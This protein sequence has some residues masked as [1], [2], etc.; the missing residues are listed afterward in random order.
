MDYQT[1]MFPVFA[2]NNL[3]TLTSLYK[4]F[5]IFLFRLVIGSNRLQLKSYKPSVDHFIHTRRFL[6]VHILLYSIIQPIR[7]SIYFSLVPRKRQVNN[8]SFFAQT[9][10]VHVKN[11]DFCAQTIIYLFVVLKKF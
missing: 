5:A 1:G 4:P 3:R 7:L 2:P 10:R 11:Y 6:R 8:T 9:S